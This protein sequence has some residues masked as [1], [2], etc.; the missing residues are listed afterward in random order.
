MRRG[1]MYTWMRQSGQQMHAWAIQN[2]TKVGGQH[3]CVG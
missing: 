2:R 3:S 1:L